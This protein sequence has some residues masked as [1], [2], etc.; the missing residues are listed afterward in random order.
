MRFGKNEP[1][2]QLS[3]NAEKPLISR[4]FR[5]IFN[6]V[7]KITNLRGRVQFPT[8]GKVRDPLFAPMHAV[9]GQS[10]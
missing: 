5:A 1:I 8:G 6:H 3:K 7:N 4:H 10:G 9:Q 2:P